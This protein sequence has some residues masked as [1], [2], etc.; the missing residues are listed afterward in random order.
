[1][2]HTKLEIVFDS[3]TWD[4]KFEND[5][6]QENILRVFRENEAE[7]AGRFIADLE[8]ETEKVWR[9]V[10]LGQDSLGQL[11]AVVEAEWDE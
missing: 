3:V 1:M 7:E 11:L 6:P 4:R 8:E 10:S 5:V 9:S 2:R